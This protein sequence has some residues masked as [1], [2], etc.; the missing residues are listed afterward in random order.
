MLQAAAS[1][2]QFELVMLKSL[3]KDARTGGRMIRRTLAPVRRLVP[4]HSTE[5]NLN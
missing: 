2:W 5:Q 4:R 1:T 3:L